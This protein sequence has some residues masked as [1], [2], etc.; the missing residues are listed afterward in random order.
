[1]QLTRLPGMETNFI[2]K[3]WSTIIS[4]ILRRRYYPQNLCTKNQSLHASLAWWT[5]NDPQQLWAKFLLHNYVRPQ[6]IIN[7]KYFH[8]WR[9]IINGWNYCRLDY[10]WNITTGQHVQFWM[11]PWL[12]NN[13]IFR[14]NFNGKE[15]SF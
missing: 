5:F 4:F 13:I 8:T 15:T 10:K 2:I 6:A 3:K 1:M 7:Y 9:N 12:K 14:N 11:D